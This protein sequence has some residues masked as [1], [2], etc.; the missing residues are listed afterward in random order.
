MLADCKD[1]D[2]WTDRMSR[3]STITEM[4][5]LLFDVRIIIIFHYTTRQ[6]R[7]I[8]LLSLTPNSNVNILYYCTFCYAFNSG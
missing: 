1:T 2:S 8:L 4:M 3:R 7:D 6:S 5:M